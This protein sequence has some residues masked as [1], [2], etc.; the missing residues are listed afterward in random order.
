MLVVEERME[1]SRYITDSFFVEPQFDGET[2]GANLTLTGDT[3][4]TVES[5]ATEA[6][7]DMPSI[8]DQNITWMI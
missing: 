8:G 6:I 3:D 1:S 2:G 7:E 4:Q 5:D